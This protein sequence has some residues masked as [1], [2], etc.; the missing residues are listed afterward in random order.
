MPNIALL[1]QILAEA[2]RFVEAS[3]D[4][5]WTS[6]NDKGAALRELDHA[7]E[8]LIHGSIAPL[9]ILF[10]PTGPLQELSLSNDWGDEFLKLSD[11]YEAAIGC[12]CLTDPTLPVFLEDLGMDSKFAEISICACPRCGHLWLRYY[13][14]VE[15]FSGSGR[16]Y[17]GRVSAPVAADQ[18]RATLERLPWYFFGGSY[19]DGKIGK[20]AGP[21]SE[22]P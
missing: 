7:I 6:W 3:D 12:E 13:Y 16:W 14:V 5:S 20:R 11:R 17:M 9:S 1:S 21:L 15:A 22:S 10:A 4:F 2:R 8:H 18:A 19:F